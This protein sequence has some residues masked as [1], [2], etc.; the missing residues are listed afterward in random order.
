MSTLRLTRLGAIVLL[1]ASLAGLALALYA[2]FIPL[3]G[4][5]GTLGA[6]VAIVA[7]LALAVLALLLGA[8]TGRGASIA[9]R[10]LIL[11]GLAGTFFAAILLHQWWLCAAMVIGLIGLIID[12]VRP[13]H[14]A[15]VTHS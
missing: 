8:V 12:M 5:T 6:L 11:I 15:R 7:C 10:V 1:L 13:S 9:L 3:T 2:Y 14:R 4:V